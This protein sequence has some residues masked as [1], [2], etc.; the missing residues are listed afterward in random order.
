MSEKEKLG[1]LTEIS[2]LLFDQKMFVLERAA[3]A[4]QSSLDRLSELD[5]PMDAAD[6]PLIQAQEIALRHALWADHKRREINTMLARQTAE[7]IE[8]REDASRAFGRN[9]VLNRLKGQLS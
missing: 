6:L 1:R 3:R 2:Q 9:Q 7:W 5:R 4:R 8:A